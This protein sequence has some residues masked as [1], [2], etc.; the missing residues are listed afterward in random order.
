MNN[1]KAISISFCFCNQ[2]PECIKNCCEMA[3]DIIEHLCNSKDIPWPQNGMFNVNIPMVDYR[4]PI[5]VTEFHKASYGSLFKKTSKDSFKF[6][7]DFSVTNNL[8]DALPGTDKWAL[9]NR[10]VSGIYHHIILTAL[11]IFFF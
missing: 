8:N 4:C 3:S 2:K 7:P 11:L 6:S 9:M 1:K 5:H 10:Y